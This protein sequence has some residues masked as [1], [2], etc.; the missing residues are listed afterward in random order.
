MSKQIISL[1]KT[2]NRLL[3][4]RGKDF[5]YKM[6]YYGVV[7]ASWDFLWWVCFYIHPP[8]AWRISTYL[9]KRKTAWLDKR[10]DKKYKHLID[11]IT[12][13]AKAEKAKEKAERRI[14]VFWGQGEANMPTLIRACYQQLTKNNEH[15]T[16]VTQQNLNE[17]LDIP[18]IIYSKVKKGLIS[19]AHFSDIIR[20]SLLA[21]YGGLWLDATVWTTRPFPFDDFAHLPFYSANSKIPVTDHGTRFWTSFEWNWSSWCMLTNYKNELLFVFV[22]KMMMEIAQKEP[23]WIDYVLQDYFIYYACRKFPQVGEAMTECNKITLEKRGKLAELMNRP[24][25][26]AEYKS[27]TATDY[28]FKLSFRTPWSALTQEGETT[29]YGALISGKK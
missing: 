15:V 14:W 6:R 3:K 17:Y 21:K 16:L 5:V 8:H 22:S 23:Y 12:N 1:F 25:N 26:E 2:T 11:S 29:Y 18:E 13:M 19:W 7:F 10:M 24:F 28:V 9:M 4:L 20:T 27:L